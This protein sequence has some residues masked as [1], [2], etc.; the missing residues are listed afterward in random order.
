MNSKRALF[1]LGFAA[2]F[3]L[4]SCSG[5]KSS[6]CTVN[7]GGSGN[8]S[9]SLTISDTPPSGTTILSFTL[10]VLGIALTP[11]GGGSQVP[12]FS[13]NPS[14]NFELTRLQSDSNL[15]AA[16][17]PVLAGSY[18]AVNVTVAAPSAVFI[19]TSGSTVGSC[20][21]GGVCHLTGSAT[22]ITYTFPTGSPLVLTANANQWLNLDFN[23][24]NAIVTTNGIGL[25][26]TQKGVLTAS[27]TVPTSIPSGDVANIDDFTGAVTALSTSS[28]TLESSV[29]GSLTASISSTIPVYDPQSQCQGQG[30]GSLSC[31]G[32]GSIVSLQG[33]LSN[34]GVVSATSLDVID[35]STTPAD[36]VE[37]TIYPSTCNG[38]GSYGMVLSDSVIFTSGSPLT[39]ANFGAGVCLTL[40]QAATFA[41]DDGILT[42][43]GVPIVGFTNSSNILQGQ[44]VR[45]KVTGA[46]TGANGI[47]VTAT[48][49][50]LRFSRFTGTVNTVS[51]NILTVNG[52]PAYITT[53]SLQVVTYPTATILEGAPDVSSLSGDTVSFSALY[54][55]PQEATY[56][57]QAAKVRVP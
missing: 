38:A 36:E 37:G 20:V 49:L 39:S 9:L 26:V 48:A 10:P 21:A 2:I 34:A 47:N 4:T 8:S 31:I 33:V 53:G 45:A 3:V 44:T 13:S 30:T 29:R 51:G 42:G 14:A 40:S 1:L 15:I 23:Y 12:V 35:A 57:F 56:P 46:A 11:S 6:V 50:I 52:L 17:V 55:N 19:N 24:S 22:T 5:S 32:V 25:D 16:K 43:Q 28:I 18:T 27:T 54:L 41:I 7:C